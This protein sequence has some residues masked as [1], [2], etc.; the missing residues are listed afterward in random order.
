MRYLIL[1]EEQ[2]QLLKS[3]VECKIEILEDSIAQPETP[4]LQAEELKVLE[5][6]EELL[7]SF[8]PPAPERICCEDEEN[9]ERAVQSFRNGARSLQLPLHIIYE[10]IGEL[11]EPGSIWNIE[12][13]VLDREEGYG[14]GILTVVR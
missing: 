2:F 1:N 14:E 11:D 8:I 10:V 5:K 4:E 3:D 7:E 12:T 6:Y 9:L 13:V